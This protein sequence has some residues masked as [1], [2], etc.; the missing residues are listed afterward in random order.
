MNLDVLW[1]PLGGVIVAAFTFLG[2]KVTSN[3]Q[4]EQKRLESRG[5]EWQAMVTEIKEWASERLAERDKRIDGLQADVERLATEVET[6][7]DKYWRAVQH[8]R[9]LRVTHPEPRPDVP[10]VIREDV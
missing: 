1:V 8:I 5:P 7:K 3:S 2:T 6:W 10:M 4:K 9:E